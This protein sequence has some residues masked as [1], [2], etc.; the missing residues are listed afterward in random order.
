MLAARGHRPVAAAATH[1]VKSALIVQGFTHA[2]TERERH[3][4]KEPGE[5]GFQ[6]APKQE[7]H[8]A[9]IHVVPRSARYRADRDCTAV[10]I[11]MDH[12]LW[13]PPVPWDQLEVDRDAN[14]FRTS[15]MAACRAP[16]LM[17]RSKTQGGACALS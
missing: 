10:V 15:T 8:H 4:R 5:H 11:Q 7:A 16:A 1:M 2:G 17:Q 13:Q 3:G 6:S 14:R 9:T 12:I